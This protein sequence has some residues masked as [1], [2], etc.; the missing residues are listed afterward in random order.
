MKRIILCICFL[1]GFSNLQAQRSQFGFFIHPQS[2]FQT[3]DANNVEGSTNIGFGYGIVLDYGLSDVFILHTGL[4]HTLISSN[5]SYALANS[6]ERE[7]HDYRLQYVEIPVNLKVKTNE[8]GHFKYFGLFGITPGF[9]VRARKDFGSLALQEENVR[10]GKD[11][12]K[13]NFPLTFAAGLE[14]LL[15]ERTALFAQLQFN[16][17]LSNVYDDNDKNKISWKNLGIKAGILF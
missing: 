9:L 4:S 5:L 2:G 10:A 17:G 16:N 14:F 7:T 12:V 3:I 8:L 15:A 1:I 13:L 6:A 11:I